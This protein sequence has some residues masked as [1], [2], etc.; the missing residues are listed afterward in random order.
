VGCSAEQT[1][2]LN[3]RSG[4]GLEVSWLVFAISMLIPLALRRDPRQ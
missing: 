1:R 2:Y 3:L 4:S